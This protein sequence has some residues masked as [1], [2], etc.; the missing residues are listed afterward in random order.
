MISHLAFDFQGIRGCALQIPLLSTPTS[1]SCK[2]ENTWHSL[3]VHHGG[4]NIMNRE[5]PPPQ[6]STVSDVSRYLS[7][8]TWHVARSGDPARGKYTY[9]WD[10]ADVDLG[11][12]N[13]TKTATR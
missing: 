2:E 6:Q 5:A 8:G 10:V 4:H 1:S 9:A 13:D 3:H 7:G 11:H 12:D